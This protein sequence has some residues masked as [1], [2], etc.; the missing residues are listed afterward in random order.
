MALQNPGTSRHV[1]SSLDGSSKLYTDISNTPDTILETNV[2]FVAPVVAAETSTTLGSLTSQFGSSLYISAPQQSVTG[3]PSRAPRASKE[4]TFAREHPQIK[5]TPENRRGGR[6]RVRVPSAQ[7][8]HKWKFIPEYQQWN[9]LMALRLRC[10]SSAILKANKYTPY[11]DHAKLIGGN[12]TPIPL[13]APAHHWPMSKRSAVALDCEMVG[14]GN[15][16]ESEVARISAIDYLTG[17]ILIDALVQPTK[18]VTDWR[19]EYSG[20]TEEVLVSAV[21][22]GKTLMGWPEARASLFKHID[23]ATVLIGQSLNFDLV[24]LGIQ[25]ERIVDSAILASD[26]VG[27]GVKRQWGLK[28]LCNQLLHIKIQNH[29]KAGHDSVEDAFAAREVVL[30]CIDHPDALSRW[31]VK[32]RNE[33]YANQKKPKPK[34]KAGAASQRQRPSYFG[35]NFYHDVEDGEVLTWAD[36]AEDCGWPHPDTGYDPW[37]D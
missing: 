31:G 18:P 11:T 30:W 21:A 8:L 33:Y 22:Q 15:K 29:G 35:V 6:L 17:E 23:T 20:I 24:A 16:N 13:S 26:A 4:G 2:E 34:A 28:N 1:S 3:E 7:P 32:R 10:H 5:F 12:A 14:I 25:H 27:P 19:T 36:I 9:A 37:S